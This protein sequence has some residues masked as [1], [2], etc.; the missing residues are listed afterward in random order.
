MPKVLRTRDFTLKG[1]TDRK[2]GQGHKYLAFVYQKPLGGHL[3]AL[4]AF[5]ADMVND[6]Y[7][8]ATKQGLVVFGPTATFSEAKHLVLEHLEL[9]LEG[10]R[11]TFAQ[12]NKIKPSEVE[13]QEA[14]H[15]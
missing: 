1:H 11:Q 8:R 3:C 15:N 2:A 9:K 7:Q 6:E 10:L 12:L 5:P 4:R 14:K 13:Y